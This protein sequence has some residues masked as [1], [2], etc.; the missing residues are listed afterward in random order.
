MY[1]MYIEK[2]TE[3]Y[4]M[5]CVETG[6]LCHIHV[7]ITGRYHAIACTRRTDKFIHLSYF[8]TTFPFENL[9]NVKHIFSPIH[10]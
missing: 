6:R 10:L 7:I 3:R 1:I 5:S 4:T 8:Y 2:S 9:Q